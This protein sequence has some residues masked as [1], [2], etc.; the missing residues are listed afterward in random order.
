[1]IFSVFGEDY[2]NDL[3]LSLNGEVKVTF[4]TKKLRQLANCGEFEHED[5]ERIEGALC[6]AEAFSDYKSQN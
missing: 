5:Q 6:N 1:V 2:H 4:V 3:Y